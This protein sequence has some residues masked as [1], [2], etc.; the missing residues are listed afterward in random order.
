MMGGGGRFPT[1]RWTLVLAARPDGPASRDA[2]EA[3]FSLYWRPVYYYLRR[4][5][6]DADRAQD[7]VQGFFTHLLERGFPRGVDP[8]RGR[9]RS[10][11]R[12]ATD[13]YLINEHDKG[14]AAKRGGRLIQVP[15]DSESAERDLA[16]TAHDPGEAYEREW[17]VTT[18]ARAVD[19]L[20]AEYAG[21]RRRGEPETILRFFGFETAPTYA[22]AAAACGMSVGRFKA[23]LHRARAR[24]RELLREEVGATAD[25]AAVDEEIAQLLRVLSW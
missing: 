16:F 20:R 7:T 21:G 9:L 17:A 1:T 5:G 11:L 8:A 10:Y 12:V 24:F 19:R 15:I 23:C 13:R 6:L 18:I 22:E 3:L 2:L 4:K 25:E 14:A